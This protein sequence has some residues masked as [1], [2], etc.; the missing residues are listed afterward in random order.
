MKSTTA[1]NVKCNNDYDVQNDKSLCRHCTNEH[2][3]QD[4]IPEMFKF[5]LNISVQFTLLLG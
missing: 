4:N 5:H 3:N 2:L 1:L